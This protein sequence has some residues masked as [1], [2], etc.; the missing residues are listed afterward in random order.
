MTGGDGAGLRKGTGG[1]RVRGGEKG[2]ITSAVA[3][4]VLRIYDSFGSRVTNDNSCIL[5]G[6]GRGLDCVP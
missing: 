6:T 4:S 1:E 5:N 3:P 2:E